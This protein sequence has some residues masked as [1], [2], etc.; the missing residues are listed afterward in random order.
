MKT[1]SQC[2]ETKKPSEFGIDKRKPD[3]LKYHCKACHNASN[4]ARRQANPEKHRKVNL[5]YA[6]SQ[7]GKQ[8]QRKNALRRKFWPHL[9]NEQA[10]AEYDRL[11]ASQN[12]CCGLCGRHQSEFKVA[13]SVDHNH[14]TGKARGLLCNKCNRFEVGRHTLESARRMLAYFEL[15]EK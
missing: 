7:R 2:K 6:R 11:M 8:F 1:C 4:L 5:A 13:L 14:E 12:N 10:V 3:G 15:Y 9:T